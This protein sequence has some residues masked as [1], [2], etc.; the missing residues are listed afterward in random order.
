MAAG[1][2]CFTAAAAVSDAGAGAATTAAASAAAAGRC[3]RRSGSDD[4]DD[5][6]EA[7]VT[8]PGVRDAGRRRRLTQ[9]ARYSFQPANNLAAA[10]SAVGTDC[11]G[12]HE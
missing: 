7:K 6:R 3:R 4:H 11:S 8:L 1:T 10:A 9:T 2:K 5:G 12:N